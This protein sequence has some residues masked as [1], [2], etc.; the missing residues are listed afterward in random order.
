MPTV[1][2]LGPYRFFFYSDDFAEP[3]HIHVQ[4][5][6]F[7]AKFWLNPVRIQQSGGFSRSELSRIQ[8][9]VEEHEE[10]FLQRWDE[11]FTA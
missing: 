10:L 4:R 1:L 8:K 7:K 11:Y 3:P 6:R 2:Q 9:L 5:E